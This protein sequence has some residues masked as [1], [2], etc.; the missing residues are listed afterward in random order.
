MPRNEMQIFFTECAFDTN[1]TTDKLHELN[2][3]RKIFKRCLEAKE[4][5]DVWKYKPGCKKTMKSVKC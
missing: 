3:L 1:S 2:Q 5:K 4:L